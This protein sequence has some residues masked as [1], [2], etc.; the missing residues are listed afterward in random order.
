[1]VNMGL[2][3]KVDIDGILAHIFAHVGTNAT[4]NMKF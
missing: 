3:N 4:D 2:I 1:M